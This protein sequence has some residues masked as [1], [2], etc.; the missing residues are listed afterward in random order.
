MAVRNAL[1]DAVQSKA[2]KVVSHSSDGVVGWIEAQ[3]LRKQY[4]HF[5]IGEPTQLETEYDQD[6]EQG[7]HARITEP[8][9]RSSLTVDFGRTDYSME[10]VFANRAIVR[11]FLDVEKTSI[12]LKADLPQR[13]QV[14]Q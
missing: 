2:A 3:Q 9:S 11:N 6:G 1:D 7:L 14:L 10:C 12:G 5:L 13:G 4:A 8:Q